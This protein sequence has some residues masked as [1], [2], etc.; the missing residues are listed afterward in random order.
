MPTM[1]EENREWKKKQW[2]KR[3]VAASGHNDKWQQIYSQ[4]LR[5]DIWTEIRLKAIER[6]GFRCQRCRT[7]H[8]SNQSELQVHHKTYDRVGGFE[9]DSDLEV[10]C[11][12]QCHNEADEER[13]AHVEEERG[14]AIYEIRFENWG[15]V[16]YKEKWDEKRYE[17]EIDAREEFHRFAYKDWCEKNG[18]RYSKS[19]IVPDE[20]VELLMQNKDTEHEEYHGDIDSWYQ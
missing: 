2:H 5:S 19:R 14:Y 3:F 15:R 11:A 12:G 16:R 7:F 9:K 6:V 1:G 17:D 13:E 4:Y 20:F 18:E 10:V 8:G